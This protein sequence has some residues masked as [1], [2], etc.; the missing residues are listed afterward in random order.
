MIH[1]R[2][3]TVGRT[4][5]A[6]ARIG[7]TRTVLKLSRRRTRRVLRRAVGED[8]HAPR[9]CRQK[10]QRLLG[11][12]VETFHAHHA[13]EVILRGYR[14]VAVSRRIERVERQKLRR[15][16]P[17][18]RTK[19]APE[20]AAKHTHG[21]DTDSGEII[22][23][24]DVRRAR[25]PRFDASVVHRDTV[26]RTRIGFAVGQRHPAGIL[27]EIGATNRRVVS[28]AR[29][30]FFAQIEGRIETRKPS[31]I[32]FRDVRPTADIGE[33][34]HAERIA[35]RHD[36]QRSAVR[37]EDNT[38]VGAAL[39]IPRRIRQRAL[40]CDIR[41]LGADTSDQLKPSVPQL[42]IPAQKKRGDDLLRPLRG[43]HRCA[44]GS[45]AVSEEIRRVRLVGVPHFRVAHDRDGGKP[46]LRRPGGDGRVEKRRREIIAAGWRRARPSILA[47]KIKQH[48][49]RIH[50]AGVITD[51]VL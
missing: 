48:V 42:H 14:V 45:V 10:C 18:R 13:V 12:K 3:H 16:R 37:A 44:V 30:E 7:E 38:P 28:S 39:K 41:L 4:G 34:A 6:H 36:Q 23:Q 31:Q 20:I 33:L 2:A 32:L 50:P 19:K 9:P 35:R 17:D 26:R 1:V 11:I 21:D 25:A 29:D 24:G 49:R 27:I 8:L 5:Q 15:D 51:R 22:F 47:D 43:C 46:K 40:G